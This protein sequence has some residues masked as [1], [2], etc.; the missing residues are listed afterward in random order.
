[1]LGIAPYILEVSSL[2]RE[3]LGNES[4]EVSDTTG[5]KPEPEKAFKRAEGNT[6]YTALRLR[7]SPR[8][9]LHQ[10]KMC[11]FIR[12]AAISP[13]PVGV[14][15]MNKQAHQGDVGRSKIGFSIS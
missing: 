4:S 15:D 9:R 11:R 5:G 13:K 7:H 1:M 10:P 14:E 8:C 6:A 12:N 2:Y 3:T